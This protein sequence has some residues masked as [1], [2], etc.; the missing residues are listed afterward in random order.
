MTRN[1]N[2]QCSAPARF[3]TTLAGTL[4]LLG[5]ALI[6]ACADKDGCGEGFEERNSY[7]YPVEESAS[8]GAAGEGTAGGSTE[9]GAG[10]ATSGGAGGET[11]SGGGEADVPFGAACE[12]DEDCGGDT[13]VCVNE[14]VVLGCTNTDCD[15]GEANEGICPSDWTCFPASNGNPSACIQL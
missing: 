4:V 15:E 10:G 3:W 13:A 1:R 5:A 2:G 6:A 7:C 8:G 14:P 9:G 11:G 12:S